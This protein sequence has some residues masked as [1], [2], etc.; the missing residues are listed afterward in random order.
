MSRIETLA[1]GIDLA[2]AVTAAWEKWISAE[3]GRE[4]K[5]CAPN[6]YASQFTP[7]ARAMVLGMTPDHELPLWEPDRLASFRRGKD[8]ER[9]IRTDLEHIG[10]VSYPPFEVERQQERFE[11]KDRKSRTVITG[12]ID[13]RLKFAGDR[14][15]PFEIKAW[16]P[17]L[18][19]N[20]KRFSDLFENKWTR[21]G[22]YQILM[23]LWGAGED[24]GFM[25]LDRS[26]IPLV[27]PVELY[28]DGNESR[29]DEFIDT[30]QAAFDSRQAGELPNHIADSA[31]C[32]A[33]DYCGSHCQPPLLSGQGATILDDGELAAALDRRGALAETNKEFEQLDSQIKERLRG[34]ELGIA[35]GWLIEGKWGKQT[36]MIFPDDSTKKQYEVTDPKG[37]FTLKLTKVG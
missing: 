33:C 7:C 29:V 35:G 9:D 23:Y 1:G 17:M 21:K 31:V 15:R 13:G 11:I 16:S 3:E 19:Q 4:R 25:L 28:A 8:R 20:V 18:I 5:G 32:K 22:A 37:R 2:H 6:V 12:K 34:V 30:A 24:L 27:L 26:G 14:S 36:R 10:R